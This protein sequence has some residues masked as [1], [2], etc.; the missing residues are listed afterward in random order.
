[1]RGGKGLGGVWI[2]VSTENLLQSTLILFFEDSLSLNLELI[3]LTR[4]ADQ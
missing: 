4:L 3:G 2:E 1:M